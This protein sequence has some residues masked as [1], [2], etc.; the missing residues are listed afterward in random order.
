MPCFNRQER[1]LYSRKDQFGVELGKKILKESKLKIIPA[2][3]LS[4]AAE[5]IIE[6]AK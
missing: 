6:V 3:N 4:E 2:N 1:D 5:K